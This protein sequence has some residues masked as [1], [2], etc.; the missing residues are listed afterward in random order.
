MGR[1]IT[2]TYAAE[3]ET[4]LLRCL[5]RGHLTHAIKDTRR[6]HM[7]SGCLEGNVLYW[8]G[9]ASTKR[10]PWQTN[11]SKCHDDQKKEVNNKVKSAPGPVT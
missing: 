3:A 1:Q 4:G 9:P 10:W 5:R 7:F 2:D 8:H 6:I 11:K